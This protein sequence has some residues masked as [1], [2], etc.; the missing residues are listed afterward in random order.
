MKLQE[1]HEA[2][3]TQKVKHPFEGGRKTTSITKKHRPL[4]WENMMGTVM[5]KHYAR[6]GEPE[7]FDYK[8]DAAREYAGVDECSDLRICKSPESYQ[9]WPEKGKMALWG[10]PPEQSK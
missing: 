2:A 6:R 8:W 3:P 10:I 9:G 4:I 5:A 1:L 7:Y